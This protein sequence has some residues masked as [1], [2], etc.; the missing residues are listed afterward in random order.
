MPSKV[1]S[2][3]NELI[4]LIIETV[5]KHGLKY[6]MT[7]LKSLEERSYIWFGYSKSHLDNIGQTIDLSER[8]YFDI[9]CNFIIDDKTTIPERYANFIFEYHGYNFRDLSLDKEFLDNL[10][11]SIRSEQ[12]RIKKLESDMSEILHILDQQYFLT[13]LEY[14]APLVEVRRLKEYPNFCIFLD[15]F[16][17]GFIMGKRAERARRIKCKKV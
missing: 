4:P 7:P 15:L 16:N 8:E 17:Y 13:N 11:D 6:E 1:T 10:C 14:V 3:R 2:I 5:K 9:I 12:K